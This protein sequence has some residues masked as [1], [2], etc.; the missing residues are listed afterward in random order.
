MKT[1]VVLV[2]LGT[3]SEPTAKG[4][5]AFLREFLS[6]RRVVGI[7][8]LLWLP[9]LYG[10]ILPFRA[11]R[12][13]RRYRQLWLG[14]DSP[15][16]V[17]SQSLAKALEQRLARDC[18]QPPTVR[19]A[20]TYGRPGLADVLAEVSADNPDRLL[21]LPLFPQYSATTTAAVIDRV[22]AGFAA[23]PD[24][25][26]WQWLKDYH[27]HPLYIDAL[28]TT[29]ERHWE[30]QGRGDKLLMSFHG[31]PKRNV[32]LGDPYEQQCR[33]TAH[34]LAEKLQ[35]SDDQWL[36]SFQSRLG[37][38]EWLQPYTDKVLADLGAQGLENLDVICPAFATECIETLDEI[39]SEGGEIF[40]ENGGGSLR[41]I[42][43]LNDSEAHQ[44]LLATLVAEQLQHADIG[45][46]QT[47]PVV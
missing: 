21:V 24:I 39:D 7:P 19:L 14:D 42:P 40:S 31:I 1:A 45:K 32:E 26:Q 36:L 9:I 25:P 15:L 22:A 27:Q 41:Y 47:P 10:I 12:V 23:T 33:R 43:C 29:V 18:P 2:N 35:L 17:I 11:P 4:V 44:A 6:D 34:L 5:R 37:K 38:A 28:A 13:A 46:H 3:P 8:R 16:R 30:A 20:M